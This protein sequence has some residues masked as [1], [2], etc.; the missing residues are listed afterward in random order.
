MT[1][2]KLFAELA[3]RI[4]GWID[5]PTQ[6]P[7]RLAQRRDDLRERRV[8]HDNDVDIAVASQFIPRC[9]TEDE[10]NTKLAD[11]RSQRLAK[12]VRQADGLRENR[13][14]LRKDRRVPIRPKVNVP[15]A[16][17]ALHEPRAAQQ[18]QL[19]LNRPVCPARPPDDLPQIELFVRMPIKPT[20][21]ALARLPEKR[22]RKFTP[23][24]WQ[25]SRCT[26]SG[27]NRTLNEY[28]K[29]DVRIQFSSAIT[30][31]VADPPARA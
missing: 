21:D 22:L 30:A 14:Q 18:L 20:E 15:P 16:H 7:L 9:G 17:L 3:R 23:G 29:Q 13:L 2:P 1:R 28:D 27:Y 19:A 12:D 10:C 5:L 4:D 6:P 11:E 25:P 8:S 26:H 31:L 24:H